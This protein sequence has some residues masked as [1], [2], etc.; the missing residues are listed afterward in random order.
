[1]YIHFYVSGE[2]DALKYKPTT[3][4]LG[5]HTINSNLQWPGTAA[6]NHIQFCSSRVRQVPKVFSWEEEA[7]QETLLGIPIAFHRCAYISHKPTCRLQYTCNVLYLTCTCICCKKTLVHFGSHVKW[8][9][10]NTVHGTGLA[11]IMKLTATSYHLKNMYTHMLSEMHQSTWLCVQ[12][13]WGQ[14]G[15]TSAP[16]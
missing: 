8:S 13:L 11:W 15:S 14:C 2:R 1:M 16:S 6:I 9:I 5:T 3:K 7:L 12:W 10:L 4:K